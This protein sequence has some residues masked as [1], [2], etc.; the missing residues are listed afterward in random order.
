[1]EKPAR[2]DVDFRELM[3]LE[4]ELETEVRLL[5][6]LWAEKGIAT[7]KT[8]AN[9]D[10]VGAVATVRMHGAGKKIE[11][12]QEGLKRALQKFGRDFT[13]EGLIDSD[14]FRE[15]FTEEEV[16]IA[17]AKLEDPD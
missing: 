16:A 2:G 17:R 14:H 7:P 11:G 6:Y 8:E 5:C 3:S 12:Y 9:L 4:D 15:L 10:R 1:M 13:M